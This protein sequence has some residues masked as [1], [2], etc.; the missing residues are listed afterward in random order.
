MRELLCVVVL[1]IAV[2]CTTVTTATVPTGT[3]ADV[4]VTTADYKEPYTSLGLV[5][6][7]RRGAL[8]FGFFDPAGTDIQAALEDLVPE[9]RSRGG[10]AVINVR[11]HQTQY[12]TVT[13]VLGAILFFIPLPSDVTIT[14]EVIKRGAPA[15]PTQPGQPGPIHS[16]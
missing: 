1:L 5:Q 16:L 3:R 6:A 4:I 13:K 9:A 14:G 2:G 10:D 11:F 8:A 15:A 12:T 7:T